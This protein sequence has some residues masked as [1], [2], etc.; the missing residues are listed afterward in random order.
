MRQLKEGR[1]AGLRRSFFQ[2]GW[3]RMEMNAQG[4]TK[5]RRNDCL[6]NLLQVSLMYAV[7]ILFALCFVIPFVFMFLGSFKLPSELFR[8]PFKWLPDQFMLANYQAVFTEIPFLRYLQNTL[9]IVVANIGGTV[10][11]SSLVAYGFSRLQWPG[12]DKVFILVLITMI[13]PYQVTLV[14]LFLL[15][16]KLGW[17]G[18]FLPLTIT[19]FFGNPFYIFLLRQ[20]Y[21]SV[22]MELSYAARVDGA[23]EFRIY[24]TIVMPLMK[25]ALATVA[26]FTFIRAW[27]DFIGPL[28]FLGNDK[29]YTLSLAASMLYSEKDPRWNILFAL[30]VLMV[31]PVLLIFFLLQKYFIQGISMSGLKG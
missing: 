10:I 28:V 26:I 19:H 7:L 29:L 6:A 20:F 8:V 30:G 2:K 17:V 11:S 9:I 14:P 22:P 3:Y 24:S 27:H 25:P 31:A 13:L 1:D 23:G 15:Y 12:R 21:I 16:T 18:T 4:K 5:K